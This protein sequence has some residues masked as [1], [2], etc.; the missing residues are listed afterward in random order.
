MLLPADNLLLL[1][2]A[3]AC[4]GLGYGAVAPLWSMLLSKRFGTHTFAQ[5]MGANMAM[6]MPFNIGGLPLTNYIFK[7]TGSYLPAFAIL[8]VG[9]VIAA[10][11]GA[12]DQ[13]ARRDHERVI[14]AIA[15]SRFRTTAVEAV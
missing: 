10:I 14:A 2:A 1:S 9:Y 15:L 12:A 11:A 3:G 6:L 8:L 13:R 5:V 7:I 4:F